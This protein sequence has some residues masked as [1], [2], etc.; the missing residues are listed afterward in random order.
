MYFLVK[1]AVKLTQKHSEV[2]HY[3]RNFMNAE[4]CQVTQRALIRLGAYY[5]TVGVKLD[6]IQFIVVIPKATLDTFCNYSFVSLL[7]N[8]CDII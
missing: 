3:T 4:A 8:V 1:W 2:N 6:C 5:K 7:T